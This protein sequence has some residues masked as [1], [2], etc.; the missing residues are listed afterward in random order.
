MVQ[1]LNEVGY[2]L[3]V[4]E[5]DDIKVTGFTPGDVEVMA[6]ME[7]ARWMTEKMIQGWKYGRHKDAEKK[8][9]P[10]LAPW[11]ELDEA[12]REIDRILVRKLPKFLADFKLALRKE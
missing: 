8:I 9:S 5:G 11:A 2:A 1:K 7:H 6:E 3:D 4:A 12:C 10:L